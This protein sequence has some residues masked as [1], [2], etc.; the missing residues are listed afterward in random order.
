[1]RERKGGWKGE[2]EGVRESGRERGSERERERARKRKRERERERERERDRQTEREREREREIEV[3]K[4]VSLN[5]FIDP[6]NQ[7]AHCYILEYAILLLPRVFVCA[8]QAFSETIGL[9]VGNYRIIPL[10]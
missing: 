4:G 6:R 8:Y 10:V 1:M 5:R 7:S 9:E 2:R 3:R